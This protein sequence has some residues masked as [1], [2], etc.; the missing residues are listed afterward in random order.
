ME[1]TTCR[2]E[3]VIEIPVDVVQREVD[4]VAGQ[5]AKRARIPGFRPGHAPTSLVRRH[6]RDDIRGE[7]AQSLIPK[8]F[9][10]AVKEHNWDVVGQPHFEDLNFEDE[11]P[12]TCKATFEV[13]PDFELKE[14]KE[15]EVEQ[16]QA[17]VT[18]ADVD[19]AVEERRESAA[20]FEVVADRPA[21]D[22]DDVTV[23]YRSLDAAS[24]GGQP[25]EAKD[26]IVHVGGKHTVAAF[27]E[28][29][30]GASV[31]DVKEFPVTYPDDY[32][33]KSLAGK[34]FSYRVE[35]QSIKSKVVPPADDELAKSV[36]EFATLNELRAKLRQDLEKNAERKAENAARQKLAEKLLESHDF[37]VPEELVEEQ[38]NRN[39]ERMLGQLLAQGIDPR[40]TGVDW[41]KVREGAR[42]EAAKQVR[43][44]L[45]LA[46]IAEVEKMDVSE[47]EIDEVIRGMAQENR[48]T[49]AELKTRLTRD[50]RLD[51]LKTTRRNQKAL[52]FVYRNAKIIRNTAQTPADV[53]ESQ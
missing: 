4:S 24:T 21:R 23:N 13:Y 35:I 25:P 7:V 19:K 44:S 28:N 37:P 43:V 46:R 36:S 5:F 42:P 1:A 27:T 45:V 48:V 39:L 12:L 9:Q 47:E 17:A 50:G 8:F 49:P 30:R 20:T 53:Q 34:T 14:Y 40:Q 16:A 31:G 18:D 6:F 3:L 15:L 33:E 38:L 22:G 10:T 51:T 29:L 2:K 32:P 41:K 52:D 26:A 11:R